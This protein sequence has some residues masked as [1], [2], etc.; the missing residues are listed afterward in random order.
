MTDVDQQAS[1]P[2]ASIV[3]VVPPAASGVSVDGTL[4]AA[5]RHSGAGTE[6]I[7]VVNGAA[8]P[9]AARHRPDIRVV[10]LERTVPFAAAAN[11]GA[12]AAAGGV[13]CFLDH[14]TTVTEGWLPPLVAAA[15]G[16]GSAAAAVPRVV[17]T[18]G[19]VVEA[20]AVLRRDGGVQAVG[21]GDVAAAVEHMFTR[22]I[23]AGSASCLCVRRAAFVAAGGFEP[24]LD[25]L[26][27]A[28]TDL[29]QTLRHAGMRCTYEPSSSVV[30]GDSRALDVRP[31]VPAASPGGRLLAARWAASVPPG[32]PAGAGPGGP[33]PHH[34]HAARDAG[35]TGRTLVVAARVPRAHGP[36]A[37]RRVAQLLEDLAALRPGVRLTLLA[38]DGHRAAE[39]A[40]RLL[41][42]GIEVVA[43]PQDWDDWFDRRLLLF[44]N[45]VFTDLRSARGIEPRVW[46]TQPQARKV[47]DLSSFDFRDVAALEP[48]VGPQEIGGFRFV[49][50]RSGQRFAERVGRFDALW[51]ATRRDKEW[52]A[53]LV[54]PG[55]PCA[56]VPVAA[57]P[58]G[59]MGFGSRSGFVLLAGCGSDVL[60]GHEDAAAD[61]VARVLP[62]LVARDP[63]AVLRLVVDE[64]SPAVQLLES[65]HVELV[66]A[67]SD[68]ARWFRTARACVGSYP[69][70]TGWREALALC[71]DTGTPFVA[72]LTPAAR[73]EAG[74][75][76]HV[77][78]TDDPASA[79]AR[80]SRLHADRREWEDASTRL[81]RFAE[82]PGSRAAARSALVR[83]VADIGV[84]PDRQAPLEPPEDLVPDAADDP[85]AGE[86]GGSPRPRPR[87]VPVVGTAAPASVDDVARP[88]DE[89]YRRWCERSGPTPGRLAAVAEHVAQLVDPPLI[90]VVMPVFNT[91]PSWLDE[92]IRSVRGQLYDNW[93][94]C[95]GDD[96]SSRPET[97][98]VL[99]A[100][101]AG[102]PRIRL[103]RLPESQGI[104]GASN[105]ALSLATGELVAFLDHDDELKPQ[106]LAMVALRLR[107]EPGTDLL[108]TD[109]DKREPDG[110]LVEPFFKPDWSPDHLMSRNYVCH[111]LVV[112]RALLDKLG[113]FRPGYD[114]SQDYDLV[115]RAT[116]LTDGIAHIPEPLY[117]WRKVAGSTAAEA[118][119][120]P[121]A[122]DAARRALADALLR[123]N[124]PGAVAD[125]LHPTTYRVRY[126]LRG[127]PKVS[128]VIPTR[129]RGAMLRTCIDSI[130]ERS[131][132]TNYELIVVDNQSEDPETLGYLG[133]VPGLVLRYP[134]RFNYSRMMN[135]ACSEA[136]GDLLLL[137]N[138]DTVVRSPDWIEALAEHAQR[139]EVG[140]VGARLLYPSGRPQHEGIITGYAGG[141]AG[142]VDHGGYW[143][144][145]DVVRNCTAVTGACT[146]VRPAVYWA[147]G[148]HDE[149]LRVAF[150]DVDLCLRARQ[151][152][153]DVVYTPYAELS[154]IE[155]GTR[156]VHAHVDDDAMFEGRWATDRCVDRFYSPNLS[157]RWPFRIV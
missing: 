93:E 66:A 45:V 95:I 51:C 24:R 34:A 142:N 89:Q 83:A 82:G 2:G 126:A 150:N 119:A 60:M 29:V 88:P 140:I 152:G 9:M 53:G 35:A 48:S 71:V 121:W 141:H 46:R 4:D 44:S 16:L 69:L 90:S 131:T 154:H 129:D 81:R 62:G 96:G 75:P 155:G 91:E 6:V 113:G 86:G 137:L 153:Y 68:P 58:G 65:D 39:R 99:E 120:K 101:L 114:G 22:E 63:A 157:R 73:R 33:L 118:D 13:V 127:A 111:L 72:A 14:G 133:A 124:T 98:A 132:Y 31:L 136:D 41:A 40:P 43:G 7:V 61:T 52:L 19:R 125:G 38:V 79:A 87:R 59:H 100:H 139:A 108:Y 117:T 49:A 64:P 47:L 15:A 94:L 76:A 146:M 151:A 144:L 20:G 97:A 5:R 36:L 128:I 27:A 156:G 25:D 116:E 115:L 104:V 84:A 78:V 109:E 23:D 26:A 8:G 148:G 55:T 17:S 11:Q 28:S 50:E 135:M 80:A 130:V 105:A 112:R 102:E 30:A 3:V 92:A 107:D 147:I 106:A 12:A 37:E 143:G 149:R 18:A 56:A 21:R 123:R 74:T 57:R 122:L 145:G 10:A 85:A 32:R 138:N 77:F 1:P 110:R 42:R 70:G 67:G 54:P 103:I 134:F